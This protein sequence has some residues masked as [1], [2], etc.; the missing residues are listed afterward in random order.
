MGQM[1][2]QA[3]RGRVL[4]TTSS[5]NEPCCILTS[6]GDECPWIEGEKLWVLNQKLNEI[7]HIKNLVPWLI[8]IQ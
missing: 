3:T 4:L 8:L 1:T 2:D 6:E 5:S 7:M